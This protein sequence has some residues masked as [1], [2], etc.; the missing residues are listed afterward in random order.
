MADKASAASVV[1]D[2]V[3]DEAGADDMVLTPSIHVADGDDENRESGFGAV[4]MMGE[5]RLDP[6]ADDDDTLGMSMATDAGDAD[7]EENSDRDDEDDEE[8]E[9]DEDEAAI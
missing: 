2:E 7:D 5:P 3:E 9:E 8:D 6:L 1:S 4:A